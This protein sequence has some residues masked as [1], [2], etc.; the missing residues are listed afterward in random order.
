MKAS[1]NI[2]KDMN[3][4]TTVMI[5]DDSFTNRVLLKAVLDEMDLNVIEVHSGLKALKLLKD[6]TPDIILLD[7]CMPQM[8]GLDFLQELKKLGKKVPIIVI[9]VLDDKQY[10]DMALQQ[11]ACEY[12]LKPFD[13][14]KLLCLIANHTEVE[15]SN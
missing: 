10:I 12:I 13:A 5:I 2:Y 14:N 8:S 3:A 15:L 9:S 7:M 6:Y 1:A 4:K 11:G